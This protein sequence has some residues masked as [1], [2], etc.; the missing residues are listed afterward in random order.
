MRITGDVLNLELNNIKFTDLKGVE[1]RCHESLEDFKEG[2]EVVIISKGVV[3]NNGIELSP[4]SI[5]FVKTS[6][7]DRFLSRFVDTLPKPE[8]FPIQEIEKQE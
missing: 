5:F 7:A 2:D 6:Y 4:N 3:N 8:I 1:T